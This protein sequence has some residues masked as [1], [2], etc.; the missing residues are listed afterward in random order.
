MKIKSK[1]IIVAQ[2]LPEI[3][4]GGVERGTLELGKYLVKH[5]H[6]SIVISGGGRLKG[7]LKREGSSHIDLYVGNKSILTFFFFF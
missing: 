2:V 4:S 3:N 5:D 7:Q 1:K 6:K